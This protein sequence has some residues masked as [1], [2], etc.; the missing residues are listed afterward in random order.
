MN[1]TDADGDTPLYTV[2]N[3]ET[4]RYLVEHGAIVARQNLEGVSVRPLPYGIFQL[5]LTVSK[6]NRPPDR[7]L[8]RNCGLFAVH[9]GPF[10][11][12]I[13]S[14]PHST[15]TTFTRNGF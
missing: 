12:S 10:C 3:L 9:P 11:S 5:L 8:P 13:A 1:I 4:A 15:L 6:A 7:G 14:V 2:E